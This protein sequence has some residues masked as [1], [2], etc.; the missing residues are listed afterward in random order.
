[1]ARVQRAHFSLPRP[2][3]LRCAPP[4]RLGTTAATPKTR[5][6]QRQQPTGSAQAEAGS[7]A[8]AAP[9]ASAAAPHLL[10]SWLPISILTDSYKATHFLQYPQSSKMVAVSGPLCLPACNNTSLCCQPTGQVVAPTAAALALL[11]WCWCACCCSM[12]S[13]ARATTRIRQTPASSFTGCGTF[14]RRLCSG[15]GHPR[16]AAL[17]GCLTAR[18]RRRLRATWSRLQHR[19]PSWPCPLTVGG[20]R[21]FLR[22]QN[23]AHLQDEAMGRAAPLRPPL[24]FSTPAGPCLLQDVEMADRFF[25]GHMAPGNTPFPYP[26]DLFLRF[27]ADNDGG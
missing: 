4:A 24:P 16:C 5:A 8:P 3:L 17:A 20:R 22:R 9:L 23:L 13:S 27:I 19:C 7:A 18:L 26:R 2:C 11:A 1:M 14:W 15:G 25:A 12:E 10:S 21:G 6:M